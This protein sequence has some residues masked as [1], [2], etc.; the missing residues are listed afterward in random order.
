MGRKTLSCFCAL[1]LLDL[2]LHLPELLYK[3]T[4]RK[5][6]KQNRLYYLYFLLMLPLW[7]LGMPLYVDY[8]GMV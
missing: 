7:L 5:V 6:V 4:N 1:I 8:V 2:L 3:N